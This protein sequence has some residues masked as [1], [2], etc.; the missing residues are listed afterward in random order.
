MPLALALVE[1]A[2][3]EQSVVE[4]E[5]IVALEESE[6]KLPASSSRYRVGRSMPYLF[7]ACLQLFNYDY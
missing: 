1:A 2:D 3:D 5:A 6:D 4:K 7:V